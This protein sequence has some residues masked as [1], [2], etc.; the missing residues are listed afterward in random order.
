MIDW[1][2]KAFKFGVAGT[3][4]PFNGYRPGPVYNHPAQQAIYTT[5]Q[6]RPWFSVI[7]PG[8]PI[9]RQPPGAAEPAYF[10]VNGQQVRQQYSVVGAGNFAGETLQQGLLMPPTSSGSTTEPSSKS[11]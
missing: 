9:M 11:I 1:I 10:L 4:A 6:R 8:A 5:R 3:D 7:G 2:A